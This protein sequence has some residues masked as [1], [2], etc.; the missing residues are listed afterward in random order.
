[1]IYNDADFGFRSTAASLPGYTATYCLVDL[2]FYHLY[3]PNVAQSSRS[4]RNEATRVVFA[5]TI[6]AI[7]S[8]VLS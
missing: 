2:F 4:A 5:L 8:S 1:M 7:S 6:H 3:L